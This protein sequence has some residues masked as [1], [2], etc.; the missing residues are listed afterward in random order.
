MQ[1]HS[2]INLFNRRIRLVKYAIVGG[3]SAAIKFSIYSLLFY[4]GVSY[5]I[6]ATFGYFISAAFHFLANRTFTFKTHTGTINQ[7]ISKYLVLTV[8]NYSIT[9]QVISFSINYFQLNPYFS[10]LLAIAANTLTN[11]LMSKLWVFKPLVANS[12]TQHG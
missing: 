1:S 9:M 5:Q 8:I 4:S 11:Y 2:L 6:A 10:M 12:N 3:L 7:Q